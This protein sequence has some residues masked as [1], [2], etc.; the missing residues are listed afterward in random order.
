MR[1]RQKVKSHFFMIGR[2]IKKKDQASRIRW[3]ILIMNNS[4]HEAN[5]K[6]KKRRQKRWKKKSKHL[7]ELSALY[8]PRMTKKPHILMLSNKAHRLLFKKKANLFRYLRQ[9]QTII[10]PQSKIIL[11]LNDDTSCLLLYI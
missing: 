10:L 8:S 4:P 2:M 1:R 7:E 6:F 5:Q 9:S 3:R 11:S